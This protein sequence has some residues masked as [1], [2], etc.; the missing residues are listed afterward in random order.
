MTGV[1]IGGS[2][3]EFVKMS[4][5]SGI[6]TPISVA[7]YDLERTTQ[8]SVRSEAPQMVRRGLSILVCVGA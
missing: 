4:E 2:G 7:E 5:Y 6:A 3:T 1:G 8:P